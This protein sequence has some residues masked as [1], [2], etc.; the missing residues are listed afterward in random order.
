MKIAEK[1]IPKQ[2]YGKLK[3]YITIDYVLPII[4][5]FR[6]ETTFSNSIQFINR[7]D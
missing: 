2:N 6:K 5:K 4:E 3:R 1:K 7:K